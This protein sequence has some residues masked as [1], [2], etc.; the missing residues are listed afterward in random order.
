MGNCNRQLSRQVLLLTSLLAFCLPFNLIAEV[1][2]IGTP[3]VRNYQKNDY[4]AGPQTWMIDIMP[5]GFAYFANN[6]G[7]VEFD[8]NNWQVYGIPSAAVIRSVMIAEDKKIFAGAFNELGYFLADSVGK[9]TFHSLQHLLPS[10]LRDF[11]EVWKIHELLQGVVFQSFDQLMIYDGEKIEVISAKGKFHFSFLVNGEIYVNDLQE[12][13][14]RLVNK[15]LVRVPAL[16]PLKG[17]IVSTMISLGNNILIATDKDGIY[18]FDGLSLNSWDN[19]AGVFLKK[20]QVYCAITIADQYY[21]FGTVQDGLVICDPSG[22]IIQHLNQS[23]GLQNNTV[24]SLQTDQFGNLWLGLDNGIDYIEINSPLT[25]FSQFN[26]L[27]AGYTAQMHDGDLYF[28]TNRGVFKKNWDELQDGGGD[29]IFS[30]VGNTR[31]QV[32]KLQEIDGELFCGHNLGTF[33]IDGGEARKVSDI[34]GGWAYLKPV[35]Y[36]DRVIGGTYSGLVLFKKVNERWQEGIKIA[37]FEESSRFIVNGGERTI[38]MSHG[39]KGVYH[40]TLNANLD[41]VINVNFYSSPDDFVDIRGINVFEIEGK[42]VFTTKNGIYK[43]DEPTDKFIPDIELN[44]LLDNKQVD[45]L[46]IDQSG[47]FWYFAGNRGGVF[48]RQEDGNF[49]DVSLPFRQL[50]GRFING[51]QFVYPMNRE[52]VFFGTHTGIV[53]YAINYPKNYQQKHHSFIREVKI[54]RLDSVIFQGES[55]GPTNLNIT[56]PF[57]YNALQ[58]SFSANDFENP[59]DIQFSTFL[60]GYDA[61]WKHWD[62]R[63]NREFTNL[64]RGDY[65]FHVK[66]QSVFES[67]STESQFTFTI[68]PPWYLSWWAFVIYSCLFLLMIIAFIKFVRRRIE[69]SK[70][71][72]EERQKRFF[73]DREKQLQ[74]EALRSEK[75]VIRLRNDKLRAEMKQK[76]KELANSTMQMI[77]KNK[78]LIKIKKDLQK[79]S[80]DIRDDLNKNLVNSLI[81]K[82]NRDIDHESQWEVFESH[83]ESVHEEFLN[84]LKAK[85]PELTP[86]E[87]KLCAYLRL[88]ISSKEISALM[89][90]STRGVEISRYRLRKKLSL[91]RNANLT[92]FIMT[93]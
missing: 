93:F 49:V 58:F 50:N 23:N 77:H 30:L 89:N 72:E 25:Y 15:T 44:S 83:F 22:K 26:G 61:D 66:S 29:Q 33:L 80:H 71:Q 18:E 32:W 47:N 43:Y 35:G 6:D 65:V 16:D 82:I 76:D 85:F 63:T 67:V 1:K 88:N 20:N 14:F 13:F 74:N 42:P 60:E 5:D 53:H 27:S 90:I 59:E 39:Y 38:W 56:I 70:L 3:L 64:H 21:A 62:G 10:H 52:N 28:G 41:S 86:R 17:V 8:G 75:E 51:F 68:L 34:Q 78:S 46:N 4:N 73:M 48:R 31:G 24:L 2:T 81:R 57:V 7:L 37:G 91:D 84:R 40:I 9:L 19:Q 87:L 79:L 12:G 69:K 92:E 11:D 54:S 55:P 36:E 45:V